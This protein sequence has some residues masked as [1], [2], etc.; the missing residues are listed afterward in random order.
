MGSRVLCLVA[1]FLRPL[2]LFP[3]VTS[4]REGAARFENAA[5]LQ[6]ENYHAEEAAQREVELQRLE[7]EIY[8]ANPPLLWL[9]LSDSD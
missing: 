4:C 5:L 3:T 1:E 7:Q 6:F 8:E 9:D 2:H